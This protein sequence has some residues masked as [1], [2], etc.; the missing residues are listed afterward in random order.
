MVKLFCQRYLK[1]RLQKF[2]VLNVRNLC[3][4]LGQIVTLDCCQR[5]SSRGYT[6]TLDF[7]VD[8]V[9]GTCGMCYQEHVVVPVYNS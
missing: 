6:F 2:Q 9:L 5:Q 1:M 3:I 4:E 7:R 8:Q